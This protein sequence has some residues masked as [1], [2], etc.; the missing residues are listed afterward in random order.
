VCSNPRRAMSLAIHASLPSG[1]PRRTLRCKASSSAFVS[2]RF[3]RGSQSSDRGNGRALDSSWERF[4]RTP[5]R[6]IPHAARLDVGARATAGYRWPDLL[7]SRR[8]GGVR[9]RVSFRDRLVAFLPLPEARPTPLLSARDEAGAHGIAFDIAQQ[10]VKIL[11]RLNRE[12]LESTLI[13]VASARR[14]SMGVP[15][16][17]ASDCQPA[18]ELR[19]PSRLS[20][21]PSRLSS[22]PLGPPNR[23]GDCVF[24][25]GTRTRRD[26]AGSKT[27]PRLP[28]G[29][30][31]PG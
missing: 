5:P 29:V 10:Y 14:V 31:W 3:T 9:R 21:R 27:D 26:S 17:G 4:R 2:A 7:A 22:R 16:L 28:A 13:E 23:A 25:A 6:Y 15:A 1:W 20:P 8:R 24:N 12:R 30:R 19:H 18:H 11:I